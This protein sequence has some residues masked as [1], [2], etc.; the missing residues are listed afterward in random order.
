[1]AGPI[2]SQNGRTHLFTEWQDP[3]VHGMA[4]P[5]RSQNG[6]PICSKNGMTHL[7]T[8]WQD[9]SIHR[10]TGPIH[11]QNSMTRPFTEWQDLSVHRMVGPVQSQNGRT[12]PSQND[13]S[14]LKLPFI[15][16]L[17][18][19]ALQTC[20]ESLLHQTTPVSLPLSLSQFLP[21]LMKCL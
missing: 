12:R 18:F 1:M 3:S 10:M 14:Q 21:T 2:C 20:E 8:K 15:T 11:S 13:R 7:F 16:C 19:T 17:W 6:R 4:G 9:P 5:I